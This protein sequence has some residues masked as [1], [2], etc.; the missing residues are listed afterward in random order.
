M[1]K[2]ISAIL[3]DFEG[4]LIDFQWKLAD[5]ELDLV[6]ELRRMGI[7][8]ADFD[9]E[10]GYDQLLN[11][12]IEQASLGRYGIPPQEIKE[13][14][15]SLYDEYD[16]DA[17]SRWQVFPGS[18]ELLNILKTKGFKLGLITNV[19]RLGL[20]RALAKFDLEN[21]FDI[22]VSRN[23]VLFLKPS[24]E[25]ILVALSELNVGKDQTVFVGDSVSDILA[26][27]NAGVKIITVLGGQCLKNELLAYSPDYIAASIKEVE[28]VISS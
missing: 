26:A 16:L 9:N 17:L 2:G 1:L 12:V 4:T 23:D 24:G 15:G 8:A 19:G 13:R 22:T 6:A 20:D 11:K 25:G 3:F 21:M 27:R 28:G 10:K 7:P 18:M 5:A 14:I